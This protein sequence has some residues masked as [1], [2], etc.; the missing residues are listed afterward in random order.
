MH[1]NLLK[2]ITRPGKRGLGRSLALAGPADVGQ[3]CRFPPK[4][5][6][7]GVVERQRSPAG[8]NRAAGRE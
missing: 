7:F 3:E 6:C 4:P 1:T 5:T 2:P 8:I